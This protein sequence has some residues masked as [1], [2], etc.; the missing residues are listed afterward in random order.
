MFWHRH[1]WIVKG[2]HM[3]ARFVRHTSLGE[4]QCPI[5]E[6][7]LVCA[8]CGYIST[9]ELDGHWTLDQVSRAQ[10]SDAE[11]ARRIGVKL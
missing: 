6:V 10:H 11:F 8:K 3:M 9:K 1:D 7:L 5:T 4:L 2:V